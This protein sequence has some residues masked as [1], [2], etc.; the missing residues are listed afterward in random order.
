MHR[1]QPVLCERGLLCTA[2]NIV[3]ALAVDALPEKLLLTFPWQ[4]IKPFLCPGQRV[5]TVN[6]CI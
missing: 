3:E 4:Q 5:F 2:A 6:E 1:M